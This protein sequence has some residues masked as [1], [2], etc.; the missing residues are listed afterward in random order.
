MKLHTTLLLPLL[1]FSMV[2]C[3]TN[4][5]SGTPT[6]NLVGEDAEY[7]VGPDVM[8]DQLARY[9]LYEESIA[10]TNYYK[11]LGA[12]IVA[13]SDRPDKPYQFLLL[14]ADIFNAGAIPGYIMTYRGILP[15]MNS[16]ADLAM[17]LGH[18]V[19]HIAARHYVRQQSNV[20]LM[21]VLLGVTTV[22]AAT[23]QDSYAAQGAVLLGGVAANLGLQAFGR[24]YESESDDLGLKYLT[25]LGYPE[26]QSYALFQSMEQ[27][28][29]LNE[30]IA[31]RLYGVKPEK[32]LFYHV[33]R[34]HPEP[35]SRMKRMLRETGEKPRLAIEYGKTLG[36]DSIKR[37]RYLSMIDGLSYGPR[38]EE[39][40]M[41]RT[42]Y[43][44]SKGKFKLAIPDGYVFEYGHLGTNDDGRYGVWRGQNN[45]TKRTISLET[46][47]APK[48]KRMSSQEALLLA[49]DKAL[50]VRS[51]QLGKRRAAVAHRPEKIKKKAH[52]YSIE[53]VL[54]LNPD[55]DGEATSFMHVQ[56]TMGEDRLLASL[57]KEGGE[58]V[59][60]LDKKEKVDVKALRAEA[61]KFVNSLVELSTAEAKALEPLRVKVHTVKKG[62]TVA[63][64][65][66][67]MA[68]GDMREE[69][70]RVLNGLPEDYEIKAGQ[71]V[72]LIVDP[73]KS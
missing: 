3:S 4:P 38:P 62:E 41:A 29:N 28:G 48:N 51:L 40:V 21:Q 44:N 16:E 71:K 65:S 60:Y 20:I 19:G 22:Y 11:D 53:Y 30:E 27:Y 49:S 47:S 1:A 73:N 10:L 45:E 69:T 63:S 23:Q 26:E 24:G 15:Y 72:K 2:A 9:G 13:V 57:K 12:E 34:S 68:L 64:I 54:P 33:L 70:L 14:D 46:F 5:V 7:E 66:S 8:Q 39:G 42:T 67:K 59:Q 37:D 36:D 17:L 52:G 35:E 56:Y 50:D 25:E 58:K 18:E 61:D 55:E 32:T 31:L 6:W 43:Y